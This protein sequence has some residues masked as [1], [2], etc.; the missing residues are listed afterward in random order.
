MRWIAIIITFATICLDACV[1]KQNPSKHDDTTHETVHLNANVP[2]ADDSFV[3]PSFPGG[4]KQFENYLV[5]NIHYPDSSLKHH[6][7]G[8]VYL[9]FVVEKDGSI[10]NIRVFKS[11][12]KDIDAEAIRVLKNSPKW[13]PGTHQGKPDSV[14][15][16]IPINFQLPKSKS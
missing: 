13:T 2:F 8:K 14:Y 12:S 9:D 1:Q 3:R 10:G 6:V 16:R 15:Y 11:V 4:E 5:K 7:H